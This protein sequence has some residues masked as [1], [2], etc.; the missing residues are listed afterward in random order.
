MPYAEAISAQRWPNFPAATTATRSP[1][2]NRLATAASIPPVPEVV[3]TATGPAV[4]K[5]RCRPCWTRSKLAV[6]SAPRW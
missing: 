5:T 4:R 6:K 3:R 2:E 1:G